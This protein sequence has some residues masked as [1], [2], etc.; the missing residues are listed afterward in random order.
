MFLYLASVCGFALG[1]RVRRLWMAPL[2][3]LGSFALIVW[4]YGGDFSMLVNVGGA[5]ASLVGFA[6]NPMYYLPQMGIFISLIFLVSYVALERSVMLKASLYILIGVICLAPAFMRSESIVH[7]DPPME[8]RTSDNGREYC[9]GIGYRSFLDAVIENYENQMAKF[10]SH[11]LPAP[12]RFSQSA[13]QN[14]LQESYIDVWSA[15]EAPEYLNQSVIFGYTN[16]ECIAVVDREIDVL[17]Y[18]TGTD[19][20]HTDWLPRLPEEFIAAS[21]AEQSQLISRSYEALRT[22]TPIFSK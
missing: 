13:A 5:T 2:A 9:L 1:W 18:V 17:I 22:C 10:D 11:N 3:S 6:P 16:P 20:I 21:G 14:S 4:A 19:A 15:L 12:Q 7:T 8:C